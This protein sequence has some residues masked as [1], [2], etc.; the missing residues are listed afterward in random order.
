MI[1]APA[2]SAVADYSQDFARFGF[3]AYAVASFASALAMVQEWEFDALFIDASSFDRPY[4]AALADLRSASSAP[5][6]LLLDPGDEEGHIK[7]LEA[8]A[9][10]VVFQPATTRLIATKLR[11][12]MQVAKAKESDERSEVRLGLLRLD[13]R[14]LRATYDERRIPLTTKQFELLFLL[15]SRPGQFV[16]RDQIGRTLRSRTTTGEGRRVADMHVLRL[17]RA[18]DQADARNV[19]VETVYG[20]GYSLLYVESSDVAHATELEWTA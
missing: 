6:V 5:I 11:S 16:H 1:V 3:K 8:G 14:R 17:R 20:R 9:T 18:L 2:P 10:D 15:A 13:L 12:L 7:A 4:L 19:R